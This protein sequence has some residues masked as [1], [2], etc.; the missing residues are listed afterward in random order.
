MEFRIP[1]QNADFH[2][3]YNDG[4]LILTRRHGS[5]SARLSPT[6]A[7]VWSLCDARRSVEQIIWMC[8]MQ[9]PEARAQIGKDVTA[10]IKALAEKELVCLIPRVICSEDALLRV[11]TFVD[12]WL[13]IAFRRIDAALR[14][15]APDWVE[16]VD[17]VED[18]DVQILH[19]V[20]AS[21]IVNLSHYNLVVFQSVLATEQIDVTDWADLWAMSRLTVSFHDLSPY[22]HRSFNHY[23][24]PLGAE[25]HFHRLPGK[26][27]DKKIFATGWVAE[28]ESLDCV[29]SACRK[30]DERMW[31]TGA[32]FGW[33]R[34]WYQH[35]DIMPDEQLVELLN[36]VEYVSCLRR[37]EGFELLGIEGL[38][39]GARP[40]VPDLPTYHWYGDHA[41]VIDLESDVTRQLTKILAQPARPVPDVEHAEIVKRFSWSRLVPPL[42]ERIRR[43]ML[44][45]E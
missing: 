27:R 20:D 25:Q 10:A 12:D 38:F 29:Y 36:R 5:N 28:S 19:I 13:G 16:F 6:M 35:L 44:T 30:L 41:Y 22:T 26:A 37:R 18:A 45:G 24:M 39:C 33:A 4:E 34:P 15:H 9:H 11:Y 21:Q 23:S 8:Q 32:D 42:F 17:K 31:H 40:I 2:A 7:L 1:V 3:L 43:E 14:Q